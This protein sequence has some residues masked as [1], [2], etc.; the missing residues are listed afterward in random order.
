MNLTHWTTAP[1]KKTP[2]NADV[3][4][5]Y[6]KPEAQAIH[7]LLQA[8]EE[9]KPH[10]TPVDVFFFVLEGNP[11]ILIGEEKQQ[12]K[13]GAMVE[14]PKN[15]PHCI[16]NKTEKKVRVLVVKTPRQEKPSMIL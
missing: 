11:T 12:I 13:E 10:T 5:L 14:S 1:A 15:I 4:L 9:L 2:H 16:Y 8:G 3:R 7:I 6:N